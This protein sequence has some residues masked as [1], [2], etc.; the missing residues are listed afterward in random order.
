MEIQRDQ[1]T[2]SK[3]VM[4]AKDLTGAPLISLVPCKTRK[5]R[6]SQQGGSR[7]YYDGRQR[8]SSEQG[9]VQG[10]ASYYA[11]QHL[12]QVTVTV[13]WLNI[14]LAPTVQKLLADQGYLQQFYQNPTFGGR[15]NTGQH[16]PQ[17]GACR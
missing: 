15:N 3:H 12:Y 13:M 8:H 17:L 2:P 7:K 4:S 1:L 14:H 6:P 9:N 11:G 16:H 5:V 10:P